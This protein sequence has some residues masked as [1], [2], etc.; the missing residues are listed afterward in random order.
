MMFKRRIKKQYP[1]IFD[2]SKTNKLE[3][4]NLNHIVLYG[5]YEIKKGDEIVLTLCEYPSENT[6]LLSI[7]RTIIKF[8]KYNYSKEKYDYSIEKNIIK[9]KMNIH[10]QA[11]LKISHND[12]SNYNYYLNDLKIY[13][14]EKRLET[15]I[16]FTLPFF[17]LDFST[18]KFLKTDITGMYIL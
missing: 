16:F 1:M 9:I 3:T 5:K 7:N 17:G 8:E 14:K 2:H 18:G 6:I 11:I 10:E 12:N 15:I 13:N 4:L